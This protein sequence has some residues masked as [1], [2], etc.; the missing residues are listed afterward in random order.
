MQHI[1]FHTNEGIRRTRG[2]SHIFKRNYLWFLTKKKNAMY[3]YDIVQF[4]K[5]A[6]CMGLF[7]TSMTL[8]SN[9]QSTNN[10]IINIIN[11][12]TKIFLFLYIGSTIDAYEIRTLVY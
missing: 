4:N 5:G 2:L 8:T 7:V 9:S 10:I 12:K 11:R 3:L 6:N 1:I